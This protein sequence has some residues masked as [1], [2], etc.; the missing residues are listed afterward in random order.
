MAK[1]RSLTRKGAAFLE[2]PR[3]SVTPRGR[4]KPPREPVQMVVLDNGVALNEPESVIYHALNDLN[5]RFEAQVLIGQGKALGG[6]AV[7]FWLLD[8]GIDLDYLG[9]WH[10]SDEGRARDF[11]RDVTRQQRGLRRVHLFENDL[12]PH[13]SVHRRILEVIGSPHVA[14]VTTR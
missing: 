12:P 4:P 3:M 6:G 1:L 13:N 2:G 8:Y 9:P 5:I 10:F 11:W 7:D 14:A